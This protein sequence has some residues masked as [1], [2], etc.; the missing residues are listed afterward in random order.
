MTTESGHFDKE[1]YKG[2]VISQEKL[3]DLNP[4][5]GEVVFFDICEAH[6]TERRI[7]AKAVEGNKEMKELR[8]RGL[9]LAQEF[10]SESSKFSSKP[11]FTHV[12]IAVLRNNHTGHPERGFAFIGTPIPR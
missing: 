10:A 9:E 12:R 1:I 8:K 6:L 4:E 3:Y 5:E 2:K 7:K 11:L